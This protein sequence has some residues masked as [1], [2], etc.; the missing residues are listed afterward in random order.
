M[1]RI[2]NLKPSKIDEEKQYLHLTLQKAI[3]PPSFDLRNTQAGLPA[4]IDQGALGSCTS[5]A[6]SNYVRYLMK[7]NLKSD[8]QPSRLFIYYN[9]RVFLDHSDPKEDTGASIVDTCHSIYK[10][11]APNE[12][13]WPYI[14]SKFSVRPSKSAYSK[15]KLFK[16]INYYFVDNNLDDIKNILAVENL[17]LQIGFAVYES[18]ES[19]IVDRTGVVPMPNIQT[20]KVLGGHSVIIVGYDDVSQ[21]FT[22]MNSWGT[23]WGNKGYFTVPYR[24]ILDDNITWEIFK[25]N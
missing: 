20:E 17:P 3:L 5:N 14:I 12:K 9:T 21:R 24:F 18:F 23:N 1:S 10:Y 19:N 16:K 6:S 2:Y 11:H 13:L 7:K 8:Y 25:M 22:C 4:V 15:A